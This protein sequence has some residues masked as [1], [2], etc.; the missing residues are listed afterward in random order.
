MT[1]LQ[2]EIKA[3]K[4]LLELRKGINEDRKRDL[5]KDQ[6]MIEMIKKQIVEKE[7]ETAGE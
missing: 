5:F 1:K 2:E 7:N 4:E 3:L 6:L